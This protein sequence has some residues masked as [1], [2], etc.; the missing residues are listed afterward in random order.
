[1]AEITIGWVGVDEDGQASIFAGEPS[2][3]EKADGQTGFYL[4]NPQ[5]LWIRVLPHNPPQSFLGVAPGTKKEITG[6][7]G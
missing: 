4:E 3:C 1:M 7:V 2:T 6:S 5:D